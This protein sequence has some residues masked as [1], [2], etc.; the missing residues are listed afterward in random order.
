MWYRPVRLAD[1]WSLH[2]GR[3]GLRRMRL[4]VGR[5]EPERSARHDRYYDLAM[6][7]LQNRSL[8]PS[9][10]LVD[11]RRN[12]SRFVVGRRR[13]RG[14]FVDSGSET[15]PYRRFVRLTNDSTTA[16]LALSPHNPVEHAIVHCFAHMFGPYRFAPFEIGDGTSNANHFVMCPGRQPQLGDTLPE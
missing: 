9:R 8:R 13:C 3:G 6:P 4:G 12:R 16:R 10:T 15:A 11:P 7:S 14:A 5:R 2:V 1:L